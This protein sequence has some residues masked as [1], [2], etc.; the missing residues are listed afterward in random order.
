MKEFLIE[1]L[2]AVA[3]AAVPVCAAFLVQFLRRKSAQIGAEIDSLDMKELLAEVTE[4]VTT[5]V[6]YTSQTYVDALKKSNA[7]TKEN[8]D[9]ALA[10]AVKKAEELLTWEA[11][12]FL[13]D[14]YG[15]LNGYLVSR[16][17]AE[18]RVQKQMD[19][20]ITLGEPFAAEL[21]EVPDVTAV[22]AATAAATAAAI[23]QT[24]ATKEAAGGGP[25]DARKGVAIPHPC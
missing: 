1:L 9:E 6:T 22:A 5:A 19:N 13:E 7:F 16:I 20:T 2:Q 24:A 17:E 15:D 18:V 23:A 25:E 21:K 10:K 11:R 4:A 8:Q 14:A 12:R 3:T